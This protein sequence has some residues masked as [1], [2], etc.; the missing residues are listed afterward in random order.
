MMS[1]SPKRRHWIRWATMIAAGALFMPS[2]R[3]IAQ[4]S[5]KTHH[6]RKTT[7]HRRRR[8]YTDYHHYRRYYTHIHMKP[9]RVR[10]IQQ[11]LVKA[12]FLHMPPDGTWGATTTDAMRRY[13]QANGFAPTGLPEAKPL[14]KLGLG[15]HPLPPGFEPL[16]AAD[17]ESQG[18]TESGTT[19]ASPS[20]PQKSSSSP[21][22]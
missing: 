8:H 4:Q 6:A 15:P 20:P 3:A 10:Q 7:L 14:M 11:A 13:Q 1:F 22:Q 21:G 19:T 17:A 16:P 9:E 18:K 12:G 5:R 2:L